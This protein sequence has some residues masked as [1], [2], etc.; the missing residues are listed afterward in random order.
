MEDAGEDNVDEWNHM[1]QQED[2]L[3]GRS[4][5]KPD[6]HK[7]SRKF[8]N[9]QLDQDDYNVNDTPS[10]G[11]KHRMFLCIVPQLFAPRE[12]VALSLG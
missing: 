12:Q 6:Y 9:M 3:G 2:E 1:H 7:A 10:I 8:L 4:F 11:K 5:Y